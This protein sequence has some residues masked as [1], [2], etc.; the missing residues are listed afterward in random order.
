MSIL[1]QFLLISDPSAS[2]IVK[3]S[4]NPSAEIVLFAP[5]TSVV[6]VL[7]SIV[8]LAVSDKSLLVTETFSAVFALI[9]P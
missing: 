1:T 5:K 9:A 8:V 3:L 7:I 2:L 6:T 4:F